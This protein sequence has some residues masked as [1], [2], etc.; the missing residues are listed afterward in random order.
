M[1]A[2]EAE[3]ADAGQHC[4]WGRS[5]LSIPG[6]K[7]RVTRRMRII[8][9]STTVLAI[10]NYV[11]STIRGSDTFPFL[12]P[13]KWTFTSIYP[14]PPRGRGLSF[15]A[16]CRTKVNRREL[17]ID[18]TMDFGQSRLIDWDH[19]TEVKEYLLA[20]PLDAGLRLLIWDDKGMG[21]PLRISIDVTGCFAC[22]V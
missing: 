9:D 13:V 11:D 19:V 7:P 22:P 1:D 4:W 5:R 20:N 2:R 17:K 10:V 12:T 6:N 21:M 18:M 14:P 16:L 3:K 15:F 8:N